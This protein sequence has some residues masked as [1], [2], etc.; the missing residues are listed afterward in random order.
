M[1]NRYYKARSSGEFGVVFDY[2]GD[3]TADELVRRYGSEEFLA[4]YTPP[5]ERGG[6]WDTPSD[7]Q[8][9]EELQRIRKDKGLIA[10]KDKPA[11]IGKLSPL[12]F[13]EEG[14]LVERPEAELEAAR[15]RLAKA[16][17]EG[18]D[19]LKQA[20]LRRRYQAIDRA[21]QKKIYATPFKYDGKHFSMSMNAQVNWNTIINN[22]HNDPDGFK[23]VQVSMLNEDP[24][25]YINAVSYTHLTLPTIYS[26]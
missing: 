12:T 9:Q 7:G 4:R 22:Y 10:E 25:S 15:E 17:E 26:V 20:D 13:N 5:A 23:S 2:F 3:F 6:E 14:Q 24:N 21:I 16:K 8:I 19:R 18:E 11:Y 1:A